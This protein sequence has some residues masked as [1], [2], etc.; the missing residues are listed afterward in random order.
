VAVDINESDLA[1]TDGR[2]NAIACVADVSTEAGNAAMV[3]IAVEH[4]GGLDLAPRDCV[5]AL[6][7]A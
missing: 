6:G 7:H 5:A 4:F 1:W 2:E 3:R